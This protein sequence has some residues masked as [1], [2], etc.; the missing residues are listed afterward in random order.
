MH[1]STL[2]AL[3]RYAIMRDRLCPLPLAP[4]FFVSARGTRLL[5]VTV[6]PGFRALVRQAGLGEISGPSR[7]KLHSFRHSFAVGTLRDWLA[8]GGD[9]AVRLPAL[10]TY[11]G[12]GEPKATYWYFTAVPELLALA[13]GRLEAAF[14]G[15]E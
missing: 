15:L 1:Q 7:P 3:R 4:S 12:H 8:D 13:A 2:A 10:S 11:L 9:V 6:Y 14:G 5:H